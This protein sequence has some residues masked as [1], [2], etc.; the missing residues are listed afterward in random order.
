MSR[1]TLLGPVSTLSRWTGDDEFFLDF[2]QGDLVD[3]R[4]R[5]GRSSSAT[6]VGPD[7]L[8]KI[9][10]PNTPRLHYDPVSLESR[11]LLLER[12]S[13]NYLPNF[14][15]GGG[16]AWNTSHYPVVQTAE[17]RSPDGSFNAYK[18]VKNA[19]TSL[20]STGTVATVNKAAES[21]RWTFSV[22]AKGAEYDI[23][24]VYMSGASVDTVRYS[25]DVDLLTGAVFNERV[26]SFTNTSVAVAR[27]RDG[28]FRIAI[29]ATVDAHN[30]LTSR[31]YSLSSNPNVTQ[32]DGVSGIYVYGPQLENL[33]AETSYIPTE[34]VPV[35]RA[36]EGAEF[37]LSNL[38]DQFTFFADCRFLNDSPSNW[39]YSASLNSGNVNSFFALT[40]SSS[41]GLDG[42]RA[43]EDGGPLRSVYGSNEIERFKHAASFNGTNIRYASRGKY[44][45][46]T[47]SSIDLSK[48]SVMS[49]GTAGR[50]GTS[51]L[52]EIYSVGL[53][54]GYVGSVRIAEMV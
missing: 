47:G 49:L 51:S 11:G 53:F 23:V 31:I 8:L 1:G 16:T 33:P 13:E 2:T 4:L 29:R 18:L 43:Q 26:A 38:P 22:F 45:G 41:T 10:Q 27:M 19:G 40:I 34:D 44:H 30:S 12:A 3:D 39:T 36:S 17:T 24:R 35:S 46:A 6:Y 21:G 50:G 48:L 28:W 52:I 9:S 42:I 15:H 7:G 5:L 37:P 25:V 14:S 32:G 54:R 20:T